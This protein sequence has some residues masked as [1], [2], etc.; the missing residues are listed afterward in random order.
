M[1]S[2]SSSSR[3]NSSIIRGHVGLSSKDK[4]RLHKVGATQPLYVARPFG[5]RHVSEAGL[6]PGGSVPRRVH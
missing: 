6:Y 4:K 3:M 5:V 1:N 2:S